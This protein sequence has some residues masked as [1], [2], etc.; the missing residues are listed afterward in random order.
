MMYFIDP[1]PGLQ[2]I[3]AIEQRLFR[4]WATSQDD[5]AWRR[6]LRARRVAASAMDAQRQQIETRTQSSG[7]SRPSIKQV[8]TAVVPA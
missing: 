2:F 7:P 6:Y 3:L 8:A 4:L 5:G 1:R